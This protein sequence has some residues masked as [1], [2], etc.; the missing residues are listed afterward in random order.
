MKYLI[1]SST[2]LDFYNRY[3]RYD[4]FPTFWEKLE[5][6]MNNSVVVPK[7]VLD[8]HYH[9][10]WFKDWVER[11]FAHDI[12]NHKNYVEDWGEVLA[13]V[14]TCGFYKAS[15][16]AAD[17]GWS[18]EKIADPWIIGIAKK[19]NLTIV[20]SELADPNRGVNGT[21]SKSAKIPDVARDLG[22]RCIDRNTFFEEVKLKI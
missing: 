5:G 13:H 7:I 21:Q 15:A 8:E 11:H 9:D 4:F 6:I 1:D 16:L 14:Q 12:L 10:L 19:D 17:R 18:H 2:Y 20:A 3:Y 22:V